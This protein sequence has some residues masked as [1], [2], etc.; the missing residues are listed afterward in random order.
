[1]TQSGVCPDRRELTSFAQGQLSGPAQDTIIA[2]LAKCDTCVGIVHQLQ[3]GAT[4]E[5]GQGAARPM[6]PTQAAK[7]EQPSFDFLNPPETSDEL[8]RLAGYRIRKLLG[9][10]GM[11]LV[12]LAE[13]LHLQRPVALKVLAPKLAQDPDFHQR[14]LRE[15]RAAAAL[16]SDHIVTIYQAGEDRGVP[17]LAME[18]LKGESLDRWLER[19]KWPTV[20]QSVRLVKEM[21]LGLAAAHAQSLIHRD[22][23]PANIW[24]EA[25]KGR[26][27]LL[28]FG[29]ARLVRDDQQ[30]TQTGLVMG[31]P[32][33]MSPEQARAEPLDA[34]SDLFSLGCVLYELLAHQQP[35]QGSSVMA[36]LTA[37][38]VDEPRPILE[39]N[40]Q[41]PAELGELVGQ[42]LKKKPADRPASAKAVVEK[43][44]QIERQMA[45]RP[46]GAASPATP[47]AAPAR[48]SDADVS[49]QEQPAEVTMAKRSTR[50]TAKKSGPNKRRSK[51][52]RRARDTEG[53]GRG[54]Q[55]TLIAIGMAGALVLG[56]GAVV[57]LR[58][59]QPPLPPMELN[60]PPAP[61]QE[62]N[63]SAPPRPSEPAAPHG[64]R[65]ER[66][67]IG[68]LWQP[69]EPTPPGWPA[70]QPMPPGWRH[71]DPIPWGAGR[72]PRPNQ[73]P[74]PPPS[75]I[76]PE[77][78]RARPPR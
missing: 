61:Q 64:P 43:L 27:K 11:G 25:P 75:G 51:R 55:I 15:A 58:P 38:M 14:F 16:K 37:L 1:M 65:W 4:R 17:Y 52:I 20:P 33:Y 40:P 9:Q 62:A 78:E 36:Q 56:A 13:D 8:G 63:Q 19:G 21:A 73:E 18:F 53:L 71:G 60:P 28:D 41:C 46:S 67:K 50:A 68:D 47:A 72:R 54:L 70:G 7:P 57:W 30:L 39:L 6:Q 22:I 66:P 69:G 42:L 49:V 34:R 77:D 12:F 10:G 23:K 5:L 59:H 24:L 32:A 45:A 3:G 44:Q 26:V 2:H 29:L 35:F 31:T 74:P 48:P 76:P